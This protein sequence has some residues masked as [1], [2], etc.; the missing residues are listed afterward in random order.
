MIISAA[1]PWLRGGGL[2]SGSGLDIASRLWAVGAAFS[3]TLQFAAILWIMIP[4][5]GAVLWALRWVSRPW[6]W[7]ASLAVGTAILAI[8]VSVAAIISGVSSGGPAAGLWLAT[9]GAVAGVVIDVLHLL[10][11]S[12]T[13]AST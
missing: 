13:K 10:L 12:R 1:L 7:V 8:V 5:G 9:A 11:R 4:L 2:P 3:S 6:A